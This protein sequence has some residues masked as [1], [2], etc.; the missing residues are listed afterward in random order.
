MITRKNKENY[1]IMNYLMYVKSR[2]LEKLY[3]IAKG[4]RLPVSNNLLGKK[5]IFTR[6][7]DLFHTSE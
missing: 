5:I 3:P 1:K 7:R 4:Q 2:T 6:K